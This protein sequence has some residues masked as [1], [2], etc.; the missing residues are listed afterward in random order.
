MSVPTPS[1][2]LTSQEMLE[3][4]NKLAVLAEECAQ[5]MRELEAQRQEL[6]RILD[7]LQ[8]RDVEPPE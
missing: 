4:R 3:R 5:L 2:P 8:D 6:D 1:S 7:V